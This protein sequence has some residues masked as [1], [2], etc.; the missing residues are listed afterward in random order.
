[1]GLPQATPFWEDLEFKDHF[2]KKTTFGP[3]ESCWLWKK[4]VTTGYGMIWIPSVYYRPPGHMQYQLA[5]RVA[6]MLEHGDIPAGQLVRHTCDEYA[7]VN[8]LEH[9]ELGW[10]N[11][12]MRDVV[13]HSTRRHGKFTLKEMHRI[14]RKYRASSKELAI[15]FGVSE[16]HIIRAM[17]KRHAKGHS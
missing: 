7:C 10:H 8:V 12:N 2:W 14:H 3:L 5:H 1:M 16:D 4:P 13:M 17:E 11:D 9:L 6:W 15:I